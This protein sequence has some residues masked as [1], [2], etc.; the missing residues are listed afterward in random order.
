MLVVKPKKLLNRLNT[1]CI[2]VHRHNVQI[3]E[4]LGCIEFS[5]IVMSYCN[6]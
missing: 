2:H 3:S 1:T 5:S 4:S 6:N